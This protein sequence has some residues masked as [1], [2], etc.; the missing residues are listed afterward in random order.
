MRSIPEW[1]EINA[2]RK[3]NTLDVKAVGIV[4]TNLE[5]DIGH[6]DVDSPVS[7]TDMERGGAKDFDN[8]RGASS[9]QA[10][11]EDI[12]SGGPVEVTVAREAQK[13]ILL[14]CDV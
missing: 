5:T 9:G 7:E 13:K 14:I 3:A 11:S 8:F 12:L 4:D 6:F 1:V 10:R 2:E